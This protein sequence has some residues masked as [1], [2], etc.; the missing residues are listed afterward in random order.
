MLRN[1]SNVTG[2]R[3]NVDLGSSVLLLGGPMWLAQVALYAGYVIAGLAVLFSL[4]RDRE[5]SYVVT[6]MATLLLAPLLWDHY[7]TMLIIPAAFVASRGRP[8]AIFLPLLCWVP[9]LSA[10]W[11]VELHGIAEFMLPYAALIGLLLPFLAESR[12]EPAGTILDQIRSRRSARRELGAQRLEPDEV[13]APHAG[14]G[15]R[16]PPAA[17]H[18]PSRRAP[19]TPRRA[20]AQGARA[21]PRPRVSRPCAAHPRTRSRWGSA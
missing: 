3:S 6:V 5:L 7:L 17:P 9:L 13:A 10:F 15:R 11:I 8:W 14:R 16:Y 4:R 21:H 18:S 19:T 12:G 20:T 2:V 1:V